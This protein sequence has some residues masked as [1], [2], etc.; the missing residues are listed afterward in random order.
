MKA[1]TPSLRGGFN[2]F[3]LVLFIGLLGGCGGG[4]SGGETPASP[5]PTPSSGSAGGSAGTGGTTGSTGSP[6]PAPTGANVVPVVLD[7]GV[8]GTAFNAPFVSVTVCTPGTQQCQVIDHVLVDTGSSGLRILASALAGNAFPSEPVAGG[9]LA[10]CA[11]FASGFSWG[12]VRRA[13]VRI[14]GESAAN[15]PVQVVNDSEA[16]Y[17]NVPTA[18]KRTG[19]NFGV[20]VGAKGLLGVGFETRDCGSACAASASPGLYY[21]CTTAGTCAAVPA[22]LSSQVAQPVAF[23]DIDSNGLAL[24]LPPVPQ[25]GAVSLNGSLVFGIG[26]RENNA[27]GT[28]GIYRANAQ[29]NLGTTYKGMTYNASFLDSGSNA[30]FFTDTSMPQCSGGFYCPASPQQLS[31]TLTGA[32]GNST[33]VGFTINALNGLDPGT[34]VA[35]VGGTAAGLGNSFDWGLPF[36]LGRTVFVALRGAPTPAGPG[37]YWAF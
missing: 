23:F 30:I 26:T 6:A 2:A 14:G 36:F 25:N 27:L 34:T 3:L 11:Q 17:A 21:S 4:S 1:G 35:P 22:P 19:A 20:G 32:G 7:G 16:S 15:L 5:T 24:V 10:E 29:G 13:D 18:C 31:A 8:D 33:T 9:A 12:S 37:P 28:A